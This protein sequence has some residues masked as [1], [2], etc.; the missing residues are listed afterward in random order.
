MPDASRLM[1]KKEYVTGGW[2]VNLSHLVSLK[3]DIQLSIAFP[4]KEH[5]NVTEYFDGKI[6]HYAVPTKN[7]KNQ[8]HKFCIAPMMDWTGEV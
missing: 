4:S 7:M 3:D 8:S 6:Y 5:E 1:L 2:L